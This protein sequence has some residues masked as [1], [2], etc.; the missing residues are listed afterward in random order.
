MDSRT[1]Q[2]ILIVMASLSTISAT[3][4]FLPSLPSMATYFEAGEDYT[5]LTIPVYLLGSLIGAPIL[6]ILSDYL[7]RKRVL[8]MGLGIFLLGTALCV[9]APSLFFLLL[10]RFIQGAGA[11]VSSVVGWAMIQDLYPGDES[12][13]IMS[14]MGTIIC[15]APLVAPGL[16]GYVH[17]SF[18]WQGNF[19]LLFLSGA[20]TFFLILFFGSTIPRPEKVEKLS[21]LKTFT[22][23]KTIIKNKN[24]I[25]YISFFSLL[26]CAEWCYLT[27]IPFYFENTLKLTPNIFGLYISGGAAFYILG[28]SFTP[29]I[30][31]VLG[32]FKALGTGITLT[33]IGGLLLLIISI[34]APACPLLI[35]FTVGIY[36]FG[37]AIIWGPSISKALQ[38]V[39]DARGAASAVRSLF[40]IASS[41]VGGITSSFL[42]DSSIVVLSLFMLSMAIGCWII[43]QKV[44]KFQV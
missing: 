7:P 26:T 17:I 6:G 42:N 13:K 37:T 12:A 24:F 18:G 32:T 4:I 23:Y 41:A 35:A 43:F 5:Q 39:G 33:L 16:G 21:P 19:V 3:D 29:M 28:A 2:A 25:F 10:A 36:F 11:I 30:L 9:F 44:K 34:F 40:I 8:L 15:I 31:S 1:L 27:L 14:W 20:L 38:S 22:V